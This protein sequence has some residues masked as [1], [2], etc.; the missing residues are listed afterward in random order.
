MYADVRAASLIGH[1]SLVA[2]AVDVYAMQ[3][4][5]SER[6]APARLT[7]V[8]ALLRRL[9]A[10][11]PFTRA[12]LKLDG[13]MSRARRACL[14]DPLAAFGS[15]QRIALAGGLAAVVLDLALRST[16]A[17]GFVSEPAAQLPFLIAFLTF[18]TWLLPRVCGGNDAAQRP[19]LRL[20]AQL[21]ALFTAVKLIPQL[22]DG[23]L[24]VAAA[25]AAPETLGR[26]IDAWVYALVGA[27][28]GSLPRLLG[29]SA[30]WDQF[31][32]LHVARPILFYALLMPPVLMLF[33]WLDVRIKRRALTW[34]RAGERLRRTFAWLTGTLAAVLVLAVLP[35]L[36]HLV[37]PEI[38]SAWSPIEL[39]GL[40]GV[41]AV[42]GWAGLQFLRCDRKLHGRC[43]NLTCSAITA[44]P[45]RL[46]AGCPRCGAKFHEW[47]VAA[48]DE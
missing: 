21:V 8:Q 22:L 28:G 42:G 31:L 48:Y 35:L 29:A 7:R 11:L 33:L 17:A 20:I 41:L 1:S 10:P 19:S 40:V 12:A 44:E 9:V 37:F 46:A 6:A 16:L 15:W 45:H 5:M 25:Q 34:R 43:P 26:L 13:G 2:E 4:A 23:L 36:N 38:Y 18:S 39:A 3:V 27:E 24:M 47:L 14:A 32:Q 30:S